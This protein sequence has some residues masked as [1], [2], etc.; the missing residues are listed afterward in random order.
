MTPYGLRCFECGRKLAPH[1]PCPDHGEANVRWWGPDQ[2]H[3]WRYV[4]A[5]ATSGRDLDRWAPS[6]PLDYP[7]T[8]LAAL[9]ETATLYRRWKLHAWKE[10]LVR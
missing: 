4:K 1:E 10:G 2:E 3:A 9:K 6:L 7:D 5:E 8:T